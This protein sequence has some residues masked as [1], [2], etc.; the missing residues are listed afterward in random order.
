VTSRAAILAKH[1][2]KLDYACSALLGA[3]GGAFSEALRA[4][5]SIASRVPDIA[6]QI[7]AYP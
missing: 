4:R 1:H 5:P 3:P 7:P 6:M 2:P